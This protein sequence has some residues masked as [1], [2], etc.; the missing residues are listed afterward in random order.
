MAKF[1]DDRGLDLDEPL[2]ELADHLGDLRE[3]LAADLVAQPQRGCCIR[4]R[5]VNERL[6]CARVLFGQDAKPLGFIASLPNGGAA[7]LEHVDHAHAFGVEQLERD[8][9]THR[10]ISDIPHRVGDVFEHV[11]GRTQ[12]AFS[13]SERDAEEFERP[14]CLARAVRRL[15]RPP[16]ETLES[17]VESANRDAGEIGGVLQALKL[18]DAEAELVRR[19]GELVSGPPETSDEPPDSEGG[20]T[21]HC[22][23]TLPEPGGLHADGAEPPANQAHLTTDPI[24]AGR[25]GDLADRLLNAAKRGRR[26]I[27]RADYQRKV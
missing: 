13:V 18:D 15:G 26:L 4:S 24:E 2:G 7:P 21:H 14:A 8:A 17:H 9:H 20:G 25:A 19:L 12:A 1:F 11:A 10:R 16:R 23:E 3:K 6:A 22:P 27:D 5:D